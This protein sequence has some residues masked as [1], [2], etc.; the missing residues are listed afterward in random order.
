[1]NINIPADMT[2][3]DPY[4]YRYLLVRIPLEDSEDVP[5]VLE[6]IKELYEPDDDDIVVVDV[7]SDVLAS[8]TLQTHPRNTTWEA[9]P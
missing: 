9:Y 7:S 1:M 8:L 4:D 5:D 6:G 2:D 3:G